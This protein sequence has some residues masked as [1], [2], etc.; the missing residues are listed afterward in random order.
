MTLSREDLAGYIDGEITGEE[1]L[2]IE[3]ELAG[4]PDLQAY[5]AQ[6]R[7]LTQALHDSFDEVLNA[8]L[9]DALLAALKR[10][11]TPWD[12]VRVRFAALRRGYVWS[13]AIAAATLALGIVIGTQVPSGGDIASV[14][15]V[16][17]AKGS[18][19][20]ALSND[21]SGS[22]TQVAQ[23]TIGLSFRDKS[24]Q[25]CRSFQTAGAAPVAGVA[26]NAAGS[27]QIAALARHAPPANTGAYE[28][29]GSEMPDAVRDAV[30]GMIAGEPL[31]AAAERKARDA[32]WR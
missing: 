7:L 11:A 21:L 6:Q 20:K 26:C 22:P 23:A 2:R 3:A 30:E 19:A 15:G 5:V 32:G 14:G 12:E 8:P 24:G 17:T 28:Q 9:P 10:K 18:L 25:Y 27:W 16:L 29:A 31:D 1:A 13:G 4:R